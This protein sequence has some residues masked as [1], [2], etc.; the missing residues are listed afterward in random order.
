MEV[1]ARAVARAAN[2]AQGLS[3]PHSLPP[4]HDDGL[5]MGVESN[6]ALGALDDDEAAVGAA[7]VAPSEG[8]DAVGGGHHWTL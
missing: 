4:G 2:G 7:E 6:D 8:N 5:E 3:L 1:G